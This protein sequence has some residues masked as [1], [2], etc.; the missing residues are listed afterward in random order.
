MSG[1]G[2]FLLNKLICN[3][4]S[5]LIKLGITVNQLNKLQSDLTKQ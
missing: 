3:R 4:Q 2:N 1:K 5:D